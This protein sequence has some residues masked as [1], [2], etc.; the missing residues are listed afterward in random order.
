MSSRKEHCEECEKNL[1]KPYEEVHRWLDGLAFPKKGFLNLNHR[2]YRH[3]DEGVEYIRGLYGDDAALA[4]I[5]HIK[6]DFGIVPTRK[7]VEDEFPEKE[8][9]MDVRRLGWN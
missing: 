3:H 6:A 1:G 9:L 8:N 7:Q 5:M 4:A 2:R